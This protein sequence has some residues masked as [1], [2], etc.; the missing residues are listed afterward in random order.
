[1][2]SEKKLYTSVIFASAL[3]GLL[4]RDLTLAIILLVVFIVLINKT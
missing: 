2:E 1:M 3:V 4:K